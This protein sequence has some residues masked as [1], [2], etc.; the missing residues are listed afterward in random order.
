[1]DKETEI[2]Y[3]TTVEYAVR[4]FASSSTLS[5]QEAKL[6]TLRFG[7]DGGLPKTAQQAG[8]I[9]GLTAEEAVNMEAAALSKL[10]K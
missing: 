4:V 8:E 3:I 1:M 2:E 10:R 9:L 5:E 6:L 7:L